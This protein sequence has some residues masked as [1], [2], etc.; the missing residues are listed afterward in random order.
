MIDA[1]DGVTDQDAKI[2]GMAHDNGKAVI[3]V[4]NKWD[5]YEKEN[6]TLEK[7]TKE[8]YNK[9]SYL[10]YAPI[11]FISA[12]TR[13]RVDK[14]FD[15]INRVN[16]NNSR[17]ISTSTLNSILQEAVAINQPPTDKGRRLKILYMTQVATKPPTFA[18][19][20]NSKKLFHFSYE[21]YLV[22]RLRSEFD[23]TGSPIKMLTRERADKDGE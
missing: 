10:S 3:I 5:E 12:K 15:L 11:I 2:A 6:G 4:I 9:L 14:L 7:Y 21:R 1:L 13:Q 18:V 22:N 8:V 23:F 16:E 20:V 19:F 17:R